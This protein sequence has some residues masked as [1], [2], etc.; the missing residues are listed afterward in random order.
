[1]RL[2]W[3]EPNEG[4]YGEMRPL[5]IDGKRGAAVY[6]RP[7]VEALGADIAR[8]ARTDVLLRDTIVY[9]TCVHELGHAIGL[10]H[11][12]DFRD[13]MYFFGYGGNIFQFFNRYREQLR[14]RSDIAAA[15]GVSEMDI[16]RVR[17]CI[18]W[19]KS[20]IYDLRIYDLSII[21]IHHQIAKSRCQIFAFQYSGSPAFVSIRISRIAWRSAADS[22]LYLALVSA[23]VR[24]SYSRL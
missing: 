10:S 6:I 23:P 20:T 11:T 5:M 19:W 1:M 21:Q 9:L 7:D 16:R 24:M 22:V 18:R 13:M 3:A 4:Q 8:R 12:S 14:F 2:Y 15:A 17:T